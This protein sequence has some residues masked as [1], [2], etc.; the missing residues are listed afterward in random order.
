[1]I[2]RNGEYIELDGVRIA[3]FLPNLPLA[4]RRNAEEEIDYPDHDHPHRKLVDP[5]E[6]IEAVEASLNRALTTGDGLL[7]ETRINEIMANI[8]SENL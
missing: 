3:R 7:D 5:A 2:Q 4:M 1:M 8:R 6:I